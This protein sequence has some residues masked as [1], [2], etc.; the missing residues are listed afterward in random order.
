LLSSSF[1]LLNCVFGRC[2]LWQ[3]LRFN[4]CKQC[5]KD[6]DRQS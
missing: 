2:L 5:N 3:L 6:C 4:T 1:L